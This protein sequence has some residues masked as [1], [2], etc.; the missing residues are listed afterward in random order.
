MSIF[1]FIIKVFSKVYL[2]IFP[3]A[4]PPIFREKDP[5]VVSELIR[6]LLNSDKP[7]MI[8]RYG[9]T[10]LMC[11]L[12]Y[13]GVKRGRPYIIRYIQGKELDWWW[14]ENCLSQIKQWSG[15][16][17]P[18]VENVEQFCDLM[19]Q[20]T[21]KMD[22]LASWMQN[23]SFF[24][25]ELTN[26]KRIQALFLDPF[27]SKIPWTVAL[28]N[29]KVLV[30]HP[31]ENAII[32][33]YKKR[34]L[35]FENPDILPDFE[36]KTIKAVQS[37]GGDSEFES[38]FDALDFMKSEIDKVDFDICLIGAGAYGFPLAAYVKD[39]GKK[40][41]HIGGSLQLLFGIKGK[42][43]ESSLYG[44][45]ELK[46]TGRYPAL[47]NEHWIYPGEEGKPKNAEMIEG[48]CYW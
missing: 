16:F 34:K 2:K 4:L 5:D 43:W 36:L 27:W 45:E 6:E 11:M 38:W 13:L 32:S 22:I 12:N 41:V 9:S 29:K 18:T 44:S 3:V 35:L 39:K 21:A 46:Q 37:L 26:T 8:A 20:D 40:A 30:I 31:F 17:P 24:D 10:E 33:Q 15:F 1:Q 7:A 14:N 48:A 42:R 47:I 28:K 23:E 25:K 19:I